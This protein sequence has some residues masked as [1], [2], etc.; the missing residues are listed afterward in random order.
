M[1]VNAQSFFNFCSGHVPLL[2]KLAEREG[3]FSEAELL[4]LV[5]EHPGLH[6]ELPENLWRRLRELQI[7][8]PSE[9]GG[10]SYFLADPVARLISYLLNEANPATPEMIRGYVQSLDTVGRQLA[11]ALE[12]NNLP[13][14]TMAFSEISQTLRLIHANLDETHLAILAEVGRYKTERQRVSVRDKFRRIVFWMDRYVEP[15]IEIV[16]ADGPLRAT[17]DEIEQL[18]RKARELSLYNDYPAL[19]RNL[20]LLRLIGAHALRVFV[21][22]RKEIQPLYESLRRSSAIAEGAARALEKLQNEGLA[23][24][25]AAPMLGICFVRH[26]NVPGDSA[27]A[28]ALQRVVEHPAEPAPTVD[29]QREESEPLELAR[30]LWLDLLPERV[31]PQ[32]PLD[33]VL[34]WII[35]EHPGKDTTSVLAGFGELVFHREFNARFLPGDR[36]TYPTADGLIEASPVQLHPL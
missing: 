5:R 28:L 32:L 9:P 18:L 35:Q 4:R 13:V 31:R 21:Q 36:N 24:W 7:L 3:E 10:D 8:I 23:N 2:R 11:S 17:F 30:R 19:E 34:R 12:H 33:D 1:K 22:C 16:R 29:F 20:R 27:I 25:G 26:Q 14:V 6:E 15:M